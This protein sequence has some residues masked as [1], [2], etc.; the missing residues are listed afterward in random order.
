VIEDTELP[1]AEETASPPPHSRNAFAERGISVPESA[2]REPERFAEEIARANN[3][4]ED[5]ALEWL[6]EKFDLFPLALTRT[7]CSTRAEG[8]FRK[9][10]RASTAAE[11][12]LPFGTIGPILIC[13]HYNPA[14]SE[15]F[16]IPPHFFVKV[17]V[18]HDQYTALRTDIHARLNFTPLPEMNPLAE[19]PP[20]PRGCGLLTVLNWMLEHYPFTTEEAGKL[21]DCVASFGGRDLRR[22]ADFELLPRDYGVAFNYI[23]NGEPCFNAEFAPPQNYFPDAMLEKHGVYPVHCGKGRVFLLAPDRKS[24]AFEDEWWSSGKE[25]IEI[26]KILADRAGILEAI[27]RNRGR[28]TVAQAAVIDTGDLSYSDTGSLVEIDTADV[29]RVNPASMNTT[30][31]QVVHWVLWRAITLRAS[32]LHV[33]KFYNTARFRARVDGELVVIHSCSEEGL[34]RYI[35]LIKNYANLGQRRQVAEDGRFTMTIGKRRI[36]CRVSAI[37]CGKEFQKITI[38]FLDKRDGVKQLT[39]LNLSPRQTDIIHNALSRDQGLI[40]VTGPTGSGKT[41]SLYAFINSIN[42]DSIN[43]HTVEDPIEYEIEGINQTQTDPFNGIDFSEGL[44]RILR[45]DPDVILIGESRDT[46]TATAAVNAALTGHLVLTTLHANDSLR[47][48]SRLISMGVP[49]YLLADS[50]ALSQAQRLVRRLCAH[51]KH[52]TP[53]TDEMRAI[54]A[55]NRIVLPSDLQCLY[56]KAGCSECHDSGYSGRIALMEMCPIGAELADLIAEN[57]A[58]SRMREIAMREGVLSLYQEG[59]NQ[60]LAGQTTF[61][62]IA[63]LSY[64]GS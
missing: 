57:A 23:A 7:A 30:P 54:F 42:R 55:R 16:G 24:Y 39:E 31:E 36:D 4:P 52:P 32:D 25:P 5:A 2:L 33:E 53:V 6:A 8:V 17:L 38:R 13:A 1:R 60:V 56:A 40:L 34:P 11:P 12:W 61:E 15:S 3:Q 50:L 14:A 10:A 49:P 28:T 62:E 46:E 20:P 58:Q 59:L 26:T 43:I 27:T 41:T 19:I 48:V 9:L 18:S 22:A 37:P 51:C 29:Q 47:A 64:T 63:C 21:R 35:S 44:R 45:A